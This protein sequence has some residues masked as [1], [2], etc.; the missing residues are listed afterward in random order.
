MDKLLQEQLY[1][2]SLKWTKQAAEAV[3]TVTADE[4]EKITKV[5]ASKAESEK[6]EKSSHSKMERVKI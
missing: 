2:A 6:K 1:R 3:D 5:D 4:E